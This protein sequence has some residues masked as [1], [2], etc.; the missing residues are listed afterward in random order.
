MIFVKLVDL[1]ARYGFQIR[2]SMSPFLLS[3]ISN[4]PA[5][6]GTFTYAIKDGVNIGHSGGGISLSEVALMEDIGQVYAPRRIFAI[7][8]SFGWSTLAL[9]MAMPKAKIVAIDIGLGMG[10]EGLALTNRI[11]TENG[12]DVTGVL[13]ASPVDVP[14][15]V[16]AHLDGPVDM[17]FIDADHTNEAQSADFAGILPFCAPDAVFVFHDVMVCQMLPSFKE[18]AA[19]LPGHKPRILTRTASGIGVLVPKDKLPELHHI[20]DVYSDPF[21]VIPV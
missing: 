11:A 20:L 15:A 16:A 21:G 8:C 18:I 6:D 1:Y 17:V 12:F 7:G 19:Q 14:A 2:S 13:G 4:S 9:A 3:K 5:E 10:K